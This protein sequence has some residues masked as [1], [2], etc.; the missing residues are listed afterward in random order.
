MES[1]SSRVPFLTR[2]LGMGRELVFEESAVGIFI[3][4]PSTK[5]LVYLGETFCSTKTLP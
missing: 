3:Y 1:T 2:R 4:G 5:N